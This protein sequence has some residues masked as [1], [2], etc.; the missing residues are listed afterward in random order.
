MPDDTDDQ[1]ALTLGAAASGISF[2]GDGWNIHQLGTDEG[3]GIWLRGLATY[4]NNG[5]VTVVIAGSQGNMFTAS[6]AQD[7][8]TVPAFT[9]VSPDS[10]L[11]TVPAFKWFDGVSFSASGTLGFATGY[12][13]LVLE[14]T[15]G[16]QTWTDLTNPGS[17]AA[18]QA[19]TTEI[20]I[21]PDATP[22]GDGAMP[23]LV[24]TSLAP[25][26]DFYPPVH[27]GTI[28][29]DGSITW[30]AS[31]L[32]YNDGTITVPLDTGYYER[33][34][35]A[36]Y[37]S[38][39]IVVA[40]G[41]AVGTLAPQTEI[42]PLMISTDGGIDFST[43][44]NFPQE[45]DIRQLH[46]IVADPNTIYAG[47]IWGGGKDGIIVRADLSSY[48]GTLTPSAQFNEIRTGATSDIYGLAISPNDDTIV[49]VTS[50]GTVYWATDPNTI[51]ND[52]GAALMWNTATSLA[53]GEVWSAQFI[54][55]STV[56]V[57]GQDETPLVNGNSV[58]VSGADTMAWVSIDAGQDWTPLGTINSQWSTQ[59]IALTG[60]INAGT[61]DTSQDTLLL[62]GATIDVT[63]TSAV[64]TPAMMIVSPG[65][66]QPALT[67]DTNDYNLCL[68]SVLSGSGSLLVDGPGTLTLHPVPLYNPDGTSPFVYQ[69]NFQSGGIEIDGGVVAI[70]LDAELG[71]R[72][73]N[74][75]GNSSG[76]AIYP[77]NNGQYGLT[78]SAGTL[79]ALAD[80]TLQTVY[81]GGELTRP[82]VLASSGGA[83]DP[84]GFTMTLP[85][86]ISGSGGLSEV[87]S[88]TLVLGAVNTF[89]GG[90]TVQAG[91]LELQLSGAL[92]SGTTLEVSASSSVQLDGTQQDAGAIAGV[93][94][95]TIEINGGI[96]IVDKTTQG[97]DI[98]FGGGSGQLTF[99]SSKPLVLIGGLNSSIDGFNPAAQI[100]LTGLAY[101]ASD[102]LQYA[103]GTLTI[104][105]GPGTLAV[106]HFDT[107]GIYDFTL[108][109]GFEDTLALID[110]ACFAEGT[111]IVTRRGKVPVEQLQIGEP[112]ITADGTELPVGWIGCRHVV[113]FQHPRPELVWPVRIRAHAFGKGC[114]ERDLY[115][116]PDHA[117]FVSDVLIP[118]KH[119]ING[120]SVAQMAVEQITYYH[121]ELPRHDVLLAEGLTVE[122]YLPAGDRSNFANGGV[123]IRLFPD[124]ASTASHAPGVREAYGYAPFIVSGPI[125]DAVRLAI[126]EPNPRLVAA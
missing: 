118:I 26:A 106:L 96:L 88:G 42:Y 61:I 99:A 91:T 49:A 23:E 13:G 21:S 28:G 73:A 12:H 33:I 126:R 72:N 11:G 62:S 10:A 110:L 18:L 46:E 14:T 82:V 54:D 59:Q 113:C 25:G 76:G 111:L 44:P 24:A 68:N 6:I 45:H 29:N 125:L 105:D 37:L 107:A 15:D 79:Q 97:P 93:G 63:G 57:I 20:A 36:I 22:T 71:V 51:N 43:I 32:T 119:L 83:F 124:F 121:V 102:T 108:T 89:G 67:I 2:V 19:D 8:T 69:A 109:P 34:L 16:G 55:N 56:I 114:P 87:G 40:S 90:I 58:S 85:G 78:L 4:T 27:Y 101:D 84:N 77:G 65:S 1:S 117:V 38:N 70:D 80:L 86:S 60:I 92:P 3:A 48:L 95:G 41:D 122:L 74:E 53:I 17:A 115:L 104:A 35:Q 116:S 39:T 100:N 75:P 31:T 47:V 52:D 7:A 64:V 94:N 103:N 120:S 81:N 30:S 9:P 112:V 123:P 98:D 66:S 5:T 50:D